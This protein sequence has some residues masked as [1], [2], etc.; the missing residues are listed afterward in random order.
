MQKEQIYA[1]I[2]DNNCVEGINNRPGNVEVLI[3]IFPES[4]EISLKLLSHKY[5]F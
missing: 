3:G 5:F 1:K 4:S 2:D